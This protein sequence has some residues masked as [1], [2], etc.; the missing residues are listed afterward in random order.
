[1]EQLPT[2]TL[3]LADNHRMLHGRTTYTDERRH[4]IRIRMSD[5]PNAQRVGRPAWCGIE[6]ARA[7]AGASRRSGCAWLALKPES[8]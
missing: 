5:L 6:L 4:L 7:G 3:M 8:P 2:D 1:M